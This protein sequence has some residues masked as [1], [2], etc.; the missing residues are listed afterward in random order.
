MDK[1]RIKYGLKGAAP[2]LAAAVVQVPFIFND[3]GWINGIFCVA[4]VGVSGLFYKFATD[5]YEQQKLLESSEY[6]EYEGLYKEFVKDIS[7]MYKELGIDSGIQSAVAYKWC[8][9]NGV[10][11]HDG[12]NKYTLYENDKD[13]RVKSLGGRVTTGKYC[14]RHN[15]YFYSDIVNGMGGLAPRISVNTSDKGKKLILIP[16]HLVTGIIHKNKK[17]IIDPQTPFSHLY[18][19]GICY[20]NDEKSLWRDVVEDECGIKYTLTSTIL[21]N[22]PANTDMF[23]QFM[24]CESVNSGEIFGDY[25]D[26]VISCAD[27]MNDFRTFHEDEKPKILKLSRLSEIVAPHGKEIS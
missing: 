13:N 24:A 14:C 5:I 15:A 16:D 7:T 25:M 8:L 20:F 4:N 22:D 21:D 6:Q 17:V 11:S 1:N 27:N 10:F 12:S 2:Y 26:A 18:A 23:E 3:S 19:N 9:D